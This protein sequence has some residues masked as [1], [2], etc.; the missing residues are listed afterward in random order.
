MP[1]R[2]EIVRIQDHRANWMGGYQIYNL[3][4]KNE[5]V[6]RIYDLLDRGAPVPPVHVENIYVRGAELLKRRI[7]GHTKRFGIVPP[8]INLVGDIVLASFEAG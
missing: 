3:S 7:Y 5:G 8:I 6:Q 2:K 1:W 4:L